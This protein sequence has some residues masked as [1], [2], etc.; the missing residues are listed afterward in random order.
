MNIYI[1]HYWLLDHLE[2]DADPQTIASCLSLCGPSVE[3]IETFE[4]E[5]VYDIEVTTNR[6]DMMSVRGIAREA[7]TI[8]PEF[9]AKASLKPV[10]NAPIIDA[11]SS[12]LDIEIV[13]DPKLNHRILAIKISNVEIKPSPEWL[14]KRLLQV[15]QRPLNNIIDITN[16]V[17]WEIGHPI[18]AFDY[19][20]LTAKKIIV[21][22]ANPGETFVTLDNK[23]H[24]TVGGEVVY[25]DGNGNII[26]LPGIMGTANTVVTNETKNVLLWIEANDAQKIRFTSMKHAIRS[27]AA[28]LNEKHVDPA[29][30]MDA[31]QRA[32]QLA[33]EVA[34]GSIG[35][36][37]YDDYP[38][39]TNP[40]PITLEK[41]MLE[42]Y[43]GIAL[44]PERILTILQRLGFTVDSSNSANENAF[45][46]TPPTYRSNDVAIAQDVIEEICRIWGYH[47][48]PSMVMDTAIPDNPDQ[49]NFFLEHQI[50][51]WLVGW[52]AQ[53]VYTYS[54][55][56]DKM[57]AQSGYATRDHI[58]IKNPLSDDY[59]YMRRTILPSLAEV[60]H[61]NPQNTHCLF[62]LQ[63][64]YIPRSEHDTDSLPQE[65]LRLALLM[66]DSYVKLKGLVEAL[67][68]KLHIEAEYTPE[69]TQQNACFDEDATAIIRSE[70]G[71]ALGWI[72]RI[73]KELAPNAYGAEIDYQT[74]AQIHRLYP[75]ALKLATNPP[76]IEDLTFT[77]PQHSYVG[78]VCN[79]IQATSSL[80]ESVKI[81][82]TYKQ[83]VTFTLTYR[84]RAENLSNEIIEPV[85]KKVIQAVAKAHEGSLV[86]EV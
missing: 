14:Q 33:L 13:N 65:T 34:Q 51:M 58:A 42:A 5:P 70:S 35:S 12:P 57:A 18:H 16:Y 22:A 77:L 32:T 38:S 82:S 28:V 74:L 78:M 19:D 53:E 48:F 62:E 47:N 85:R 44:K 23:S 2:T 52:G 50:K 43:M 6:V 26:D 75:H 63:N 72:G 79:T 15:G 40:Q 60:A 31:V 61:K 45:V 73:S 64:I 17:M 46:V 76:I 3:R 7:A 41:S 25:D 29:L 1:P 68:Q 49:H 55:V 81:K 27:Q 69:A 83:N 86:G 30:G 59:A 9:G 84:S 39:P 36:T 67:L 24:I 21:R 10:S 20:R 37:L 4:S 11:A 71:Q 56:S 8:L 66:T 54:M 80:I